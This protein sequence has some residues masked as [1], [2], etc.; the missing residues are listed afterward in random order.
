MRGKDAKKGSFVVVARITP[1]HAG[2][3]LC[4]VVKKQVHQDHPRT[5]GEKVPCLLPRYLLPGSPPHMRGKEWL[6]Q[7][8]AKAQGITPAH[9]G[10]SLFL[11]RRYP[12]YQDHPRTCGEKAPPNLIRHTNEG[13]PPHM[14]GKACSHADPHNKRRIT[15]AHAGKRSKPADYIIPSEDHPRTCGEKRALFTPF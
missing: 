1:A 3:R 14:R 8:V 12:A 4:P 13:S 9:A 2:K 10:K 15:P 11:R 5:C 6:P 7:T